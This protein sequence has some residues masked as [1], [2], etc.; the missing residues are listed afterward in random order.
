MDMSFANQALAA[1]WVLKNRSELENR[2][3]DV[4]KDI[5]AGIARL[6]LETMGVDL[7]VLTK[8]QEEYLSS[9]TTGTLSAASTWA[10][11]AWPSVAATD[12]SGSVVAS[13]C[14]P[15]AKRPT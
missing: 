4:P 11:R 7:D 5:D 9:W 3:Y 10:R 1:E 2:V 6:K 8:A 15:R 13:R 14:Q 12:R